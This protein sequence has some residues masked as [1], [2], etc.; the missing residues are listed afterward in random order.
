VRGSQNVRQTRTL[1]S[2][3]TD[4]RSTN[5]NAARSGSP[6]VWPRTPATPLEVVI[7]GTVAS[8]DVDQCMSRAQRTLGRA[9]SA[10]IV[11]PAE[12][13]AMLAEPHVLILG[14][15]ASA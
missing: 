9:V 5:A 14:D 6:V 12:M 11:P 13:T 7:A 15:V 3:N 8:D 4:N 1:R 2:A 10:R